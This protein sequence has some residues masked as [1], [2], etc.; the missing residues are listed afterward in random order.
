M[1]T[2]VDAYIH[3][4]IHTYYFHAYGKALIAANVVDGVMSTRYIYVYAYIHITYINVGK[5]S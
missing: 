4:Y 5:H 2:C 3:T 1:R